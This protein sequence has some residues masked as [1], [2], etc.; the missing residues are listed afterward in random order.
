RLAGAGRPGDQKH[1]TRAN[2]QRADG[3]RRSQLL[4]RQ[5]LARNPPHYHADRLLLFEDRDPEAHAVQVLD[6]EVGPALLLQLLLAAG[7]GDRLHEAGGVIVVED[8]A[9]DIQLPQPPVVTD[10]GRLADADV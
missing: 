3:L 7:G 2:D 1:P 10:D 6:R 9:A 5:E 4:E 8:D